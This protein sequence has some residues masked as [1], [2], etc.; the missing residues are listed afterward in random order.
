VTEHVSGSTTEAATPLAGWF[1]TAGH[2]LVQQRFYAA[3]DCAGSLCWTDDPASA[4]QFPMRQDAEHFAS[5]A[6]PDEDWAVC[7]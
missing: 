7:R 1:V 6:C 4:E 5:L 2:P 3:I